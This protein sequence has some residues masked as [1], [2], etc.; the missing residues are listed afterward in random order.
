MKYLPDYSYIIGS[1][2]GNQK[3]GVIFSEKYKSQFD[4]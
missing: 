3:V 4:W 1:G 2:G